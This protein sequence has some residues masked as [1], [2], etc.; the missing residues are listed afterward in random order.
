MS[1][2]QLLNI[3]ILVFA[4]L[5]LLFLLHW[6]LKRIEKKRHVAIKQ[7]DYMHA[8]P[9]SSPLEKPLRDAQRTRTQSVNFRFSIIRHAITM[10]IFLLVVFAVG[11][12]FLDRI[13]ATLLSLF[14]ASFGVVLG[15][16]ARPFIENLI[17]GIVITF[18]RHLRIGDT[19][20]ID[21]HYGTIEDITPIYTIVKGWDW[22][23]YV[24]PNADMLSKEF[25]SLTLG[26]NYRWSYVEFWVALDTDIAEFKAHAIRIAS[27]CP[28]F[29]P[30]EDPS[31]WVMGME[32]EGVRCW[33]A[34]WA[35][36]PGDAWMLASEMRTGLAEQLR[37]L[38]ISPHRYHVDF[39]GGSDEA[40]L[41]KG[42]GSVG[43][44]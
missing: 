13:P 28:H 36:T 10:F 15:I 38:K 16:A 40:V 4:G 14:V 43:S 23:R 27:E 22:R 18:S 35:D 25:V 12:S 21:K 34:A 30:H 41:H 9:T 37:L 26:D 20:D 32:K 6:L 29:S 17:A 44:S 19:V 24:I 31:F 8:V 42:K 11:I 33:L 7:D 39:S 2:I 1:Y 5:G 3:T